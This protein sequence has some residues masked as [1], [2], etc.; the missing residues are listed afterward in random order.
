M[1]NDKVK[2]H[3]EFERYKIQSTISYFYQQ[4]VMLRW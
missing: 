3:I 4:I 1:K 2:K